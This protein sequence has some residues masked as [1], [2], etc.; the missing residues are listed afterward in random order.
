M[1]IFVTKN[2]F[3]LFDIVLSSGQTIFVTNNNENVTFE[4]NDYLANHGMQ[5]V[6]LKKDITVESDEMDL[7]FF[8]YD[9]VFKIDDLQKNLLQNIGIT[10]FRIYNNNKKQIIFVGDVAKIAIDDF[11]FTM[12]VASQK[13]KLFSTIC[14][15]F[16]PTCR[17]NLGGAQCQVDLNSKKVSGI[18]TA[19]T[20]NQMSIVCNTLTQENGFFDYGYIIFDNDKNK[21][22]VVR[23]F[24]QGGKIF[25]IQSQ[26][27]AR[28]ILK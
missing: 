14:K 9:I 6:K 23:N 21:K 24:F 18:V 12:K 27:L 15:L 4:S 28:F 11:Q 1:N 17:A 16:S 25:S 7:E 13:Q 10:L 3:F 22:I 19:I 5:I 26:L 8:L 20:T 2:I